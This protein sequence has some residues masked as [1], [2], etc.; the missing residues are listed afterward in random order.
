MARVP[1]GEV[2]KF[3]RDLT[4]RYMDLFKDAMPKF[5]LSRGESPPPL[6]VPMTLQAWISRFSKRSHWL[7]QG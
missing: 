2:S 5:S 3:A 6:G 4:E 1:W 7:F